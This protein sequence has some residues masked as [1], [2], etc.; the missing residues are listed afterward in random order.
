MS[1]HR[2]YGATG[3]GSRLPDAT[4]TLDLPEIWRDRARIIRAGAG[5]A[6][7]DSVIERCA[8]VSKAWDD[9]A[10]ELLDALNEQRQGG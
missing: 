4:F 1:E 6:M 8:A 9:A 5:G 10:N 2:G 3:N 7:T